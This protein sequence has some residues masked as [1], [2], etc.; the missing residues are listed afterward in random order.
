MEKNMCKILG[1][2]AIVGL[3]AIG[4]IA[5]AGLV[6]NV[7]PKTGLALDASP[8]EG[9]LKII[10]KELPQGPQQQEP[11]EQPYEGGTYAAPDYLGWGD[12]ETLPFPSGWLNNIFK[13][14]Y[15]CTLI[16]IARGDQYASFTCRIRNVGNSII[17]NGASI[18]RILVRHWYGLKVIDDSFDVPPL[19]RFISLKEH[20]TNTVLWE[21]GGYAKVDV[22]KGDS[23]D[24]W[25][26]DAFRFRVRPFLGNNV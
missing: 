25:F 24:E 22:D 19:L 5:S 2:A 3:L 13:P 6:L 18:G 16:T 10:T 8:N 12:D 9:E 4:S 7:S 20:T 21:I 15:V 14:Q 23:I 26:G 17:G 1:A 11:P